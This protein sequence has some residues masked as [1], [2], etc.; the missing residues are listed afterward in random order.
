MN[1]STR[2]QWIDTSYGVA[3]TVFVHAAILLLIWA[4][5]SLRN[6]TA[7]PVQTTISARLVAEETTIREIAEPSPAAPVETPEVDREA[8][9]EREA[10]LQRQAEEARERERQ[11]EAERVAEAQR[12]ADLRRQQEAEQQRQAELQRQ[13][14][15]EAEQRR[16]REAEAEQQRQ[17]ELKRQQEAEAE[18]QRQA[19]LKRQQEAEAERQRQAELRRQREAEAAARARQAELDAQLRDA[20][21]A[22]AAREGAINAGLLQQYIEVIRQKVE[23]N[24]NRPAG[25][26]DGIRCEVAVRQLRNG[27]VVSV[28]VTDCAGG[29]VL[30]RSI[31]TAVRRA[32]PLPPPKDP[33]LFEANLRFPFRTGE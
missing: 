24:W 16:Q 21:E 11:A 15:A 32:S 4:S 5:W 17:A 6:D 25:V 1:A 30:I 14:E 27:E 13:Q 18:R 8:E 2:G 9:R 23:R 19:E 12:Q 29:E 10:E 31:E 26:P 3:G 7:E 22:E 28:R 33:S 20:L